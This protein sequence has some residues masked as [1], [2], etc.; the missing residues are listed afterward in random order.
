[1]SVDPGRLPLRDIHLPP[2]ISWW[3]PAPGWWL[4]LILGLLVLVAGLSLGW[5]YRRTKFKRAASRVL[6]EIEADYR[7][8]GDSRRLASEL[9]VLLR[10]ACLGTYSRAEVAGLTGEA[11]LK[12]LDQGVVDGGFSRGVGRYLVTAPYQPESRADGDALLVLVRQWIRRLPARRA[13]RGG[14]A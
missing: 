7:R 14:G 3:P 6:A 2:P 13:S 9:S 10:R 8:T 1:M 11:W 12:W 4:L 5:F